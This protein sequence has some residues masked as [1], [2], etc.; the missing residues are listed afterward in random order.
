MR[1]S[2]LATDYDNTLA[3][4]GAVSAEAW[5]AL[6]RLRRSG[7]ELVLVTGRELDDLLAI[8]AHPELFSRI[9]AENGGLL[10][11]PDTGE[12]HTLAPPPPA[13]FAE[14][15]R[16]RGVL[17]LGV[18]KTLIAT[19]HPY[20]RIVLE[21]IRE[22]GLDQHIVFNGDA[23]MVVAPGVNKAS[24]LMAALDDLGLSARNAV[25]VGDAQNDHPLLAA[26]EL[27]VAV[28]NAAPR[29]SERADFTLEVAN[30]A[31]VAALVDELVQS[32]LAARM[33]N[34]CPLRLG[35]R[36][37]TN[38]TT[39]PERT[40][41]EAADLLLEPPAQSMLIVGASSSGKS[42][43]TRAVL[44]QLTAQGYQ[45]CVIDPEGDHDE[46]QGAIS[47]GDARA[48][49]SPE[50]LESVLAH[51]SL[52]V[53]LNLMALPFADRPGFCAQISAS[54]HALYARTG[55]PHWIVFEEAQHLFVPDAAGVRMPAAPA[56]LSTLYV[57][58]RAEALPGTLLGTVDTVVAAA[59]QA[60]EALAAF[61]RCRGIEAPTLA[62]EPAQGTMVLWRPG[63]GHRHAAVP[64]VPARARQSHRRHVRKYAQGMLIPERSF[65]FRGPDGALNLRAHNLTLFVELAQG[66]DDE[67]WDWH[68]QRGDY[69]RW[70]GEVIGDR[71]LERVAQAALEARRQ[72][73]DAAA[74]RD[75]IC[76]AIA[77]RYTV[78]E[79]PTM[80]NLLATP[81]TPSGEA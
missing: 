42:F 1:F 25:A 80:P 10:Y 68:L 9:V 48:A 8:C 13:G 32:D 40:G 43:F 73:A 70:F 7:R 31:G 53:S 3:T 39:E 61:A 30:G 35:E 57:A 76:G 37:G 34:K 72:G 27:G 66:V 21:T 44:E 74:T 38:E 19:M 71:D 36:A 18:G 64:F 28:A 67:T 79:M 16:A 47:L 65:W 49:P 41:G 23:V 59:A 56:G 22:M 4:N 54:L 46:L 26:A 33:T 5:E 60:G 29:L 11:R 6:T 63:G 45:F 77:C 69:A 58:P 24:G 14:A 62:A 75:R 81:R 15:L 55:R 20:E 78:P 17:H 51:P 50:A 2:V 52:S 12:L